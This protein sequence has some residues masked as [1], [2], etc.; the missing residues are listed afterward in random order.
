MTELQLN[1]LA[2]QWVAHVKAV[3]V[4]LIRVLL[5][6]LAGSQD[7]AYGGSLSGMIFM[8]VTKAAALLHIYTGLSSVLK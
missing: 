7:L 3:L 8:F 5:R 4:S 1:E 6:V 2:P